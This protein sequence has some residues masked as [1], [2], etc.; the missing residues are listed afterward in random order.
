MILPLFT[1]TA[2]S[3][4]FSLPFGRLHG[5]HAIFYLTFHPFLLPMWSM[6]L[7]FH[8]SFTMLHTFSDNDGC[9]FMNKFV[10][11]THVG[12]YYLFYRY[13]WLYLFS[14]LP[15]TLGVFSWGVLVHSLSPLGSIPTALGKD[16]LRRPCIRNPVG[17]IVQDSQGIL[18]TFLEF[19]ETLHQ[20]QTRQTD[21]EISYLEDL[22]L[23]SVNVEDS[24]SLE[25]CITQQEI[26]GAI[27]SL[28]P[29][30]SPGFDKLTADCY[31]LHKENLVPHLQK[32]FIA[33]EKEGILPES[34]KEV[35]IEVI[36]K[37]WKDP[38]DCESYRP[39]S[40]INSDVKILS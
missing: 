34:M 16:L 37:P 20:S 22:P 31:R 11:F 24:N 18:N 26:C 14:S 3:P 10:I 9:W 30:K 29:G 19:Y 21:Q 2:H 5:P 6:F 28:K 32:V 33:A 39:I 7:F 36:P 35:L 27:S 1:L 15:N 25:Y 23:S 17:N 12:P 8:S 38:L 4:V 40:L 13:I